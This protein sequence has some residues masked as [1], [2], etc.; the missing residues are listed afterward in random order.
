MLP[1][2]DIPW[3]PNGLRH[4]YGSYR[5]AQVKSA[6]QVA[7][8]MGNTPQMI[9]GHYRS[10]VTE[11]DA[12]YWFGLSPEQAKKFAKIRSMKALAAA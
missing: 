7:L 9:F 11:K 12:E 4:S 5:L 2:F 8:E 10:V 3:P 6:P 1:K